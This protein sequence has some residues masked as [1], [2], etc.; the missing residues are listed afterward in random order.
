MSDPDYNIAMPFVTVA[1]KGGPHDDQAY[2]CG[3]EMGYLDATLDALS[4]AGQVTS[5]TVTIHR[6]N[7]GQADLIGMQYNLTMSVG[8]WTDP[9][10]DD[11]VREEW[12]PVR[13]DWP[14]LETEP[15][16]GGGVT[17]DELEAYHS[18]VGDAE[19][20]TCPKCGRTSHHP[21]DARFG[22]CGHCHDYTGA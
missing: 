14:E 22:Y 3:Y 4:Q 13:F 18:R 19:L 20:F 2:T 17:L 11:R 15:D 12:A 5:W 10:V 6:E 7:I 9:S 16:T 1:S 8:E 21:M